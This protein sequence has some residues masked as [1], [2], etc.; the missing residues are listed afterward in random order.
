[1]TASAVSATD[2]PVVSSSS[3]RGVVSA[4]RLVRAEVDVLAGERSYLGQLRYATKVVRS[5]EVH[6]LA[7]NE[8]DVAAEVSDLRE[9]WPNVEVG[10][11]LVD[12]RGGF[13]ARTLIRTLSKEK[14]PFSRRSCSLLLAPKASARLS[15]SR[16]CCFS[17]ARF[18]GSKRSGS[19]RTFQENTFGG[20]Q[21]HYEATLGLAASATMPRC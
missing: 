11:L 21:A 12:Q 16:D 10:K 2:R 6:R 3:T 19:M 15:S 20:Q 13:A 7:T 4:A 18:A 8:H 5:P 14:T 9:D 17:R 1:V